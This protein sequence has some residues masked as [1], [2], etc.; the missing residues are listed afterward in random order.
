MRERDGNVRAFP[1]EAT[2][3]IHLQ[4]GIVENVERGA[5]IYTDSFPAYNGLPGYHHESV[6]H[7]AG[8]YVRGSVHTNSIE[9]FWALFKRG[10]VGTHHWM[11]PKHLHRYVDEFSYRL[12]DG[13]DNTPL[14][15]ER[16]VDGMIGRRLTYERLTA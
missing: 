10:Y 12:N 15:L 8:E 6:A 3:R 13:L 7:T 11:S 1:I 4:S 9:S 2:D 14:T 16:T 5:T